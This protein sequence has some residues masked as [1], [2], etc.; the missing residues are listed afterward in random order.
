MITVY[1]DFKSAAC[2]LALRPTL[3]LIDRHGL[4]VAWRAFR[5][6]ERDVPD[7]VAD[8]TVAQTHRR[9]RDAARRAMHLKYAAI[10]GVDL[11][12]PPVA[13]DADLALGALCEMAGDPIEFIKAAF[14]AYWDQRLNL[15]D[16][17][18]VAR[19]IQT[20]RAPYSGDLSS[21]R[22]AL[23]AAQEQAEAD[24]IVDAPAYVIGDQI[25]IGRQNFPW[26]E[27]NRKRDGLRGPSRARS[28]IC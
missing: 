13:G 12:F 16:E 9:V 23:D 6:F 28:L 14:A 5:T 22:E 1:I 19:L 24:G 20:S 2:H 27:G 15:N 8:E 18:V 11:Q 10:L 25:F 21:A 7:E 26:I 3:A 4:D 17:N